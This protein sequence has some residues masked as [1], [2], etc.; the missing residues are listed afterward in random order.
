[1]I[2]ATEL[3]KEFK[4]LCGNLEICANTVS[5]PHTAQ[6]GSLCFA[7]NLEN[8]LKALKS[9]CSLLIITDELLEPV[10]S[11]LLNSQTNQ[12]QVCI[13]SSP[14][15]KLAMSKVLPH[16]DF[17]ADR[18]DFNKS[19]SAS[20]HPT[21]KL[22]AEVVLSPFSVIGAHVEIGPNCWIGPHVVIEPGASIGENTVL[23]SHVVIGAKSIIGTNCIIHSHTTIGSDGFGYLEVKPADST[24]SKLNSLPL[25]IPQIGIVVLGNHVEIGANCAI[26]RATIGET[27]IGSYTKLDNHVHIA[28]NCQIGEACLIAGGFMVAGSSRIG[29]NFRVGGGSVVTDHVKIC[30]NVM[31]AGRSTVTKD[32]EK[33]GAYGG[34]PLQPLK[35]ALRTIANLPKISE[36]RQQI[37][38]IQERFKSP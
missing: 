10:Q 16:F 28:H 5:T 9:G 14:N 19:T 33:P 35:E 22:G 8:F 21:A 37:R 7:G 11:I 18:F 26:D 31:L 24:P 2:R 6:P 15:L 32:I 29:D 1:M 17:L 38:E 13:F 27:V 23:H 30:N 25:K 3:Q 20:I 36:L 4:H 34:Y 12:N